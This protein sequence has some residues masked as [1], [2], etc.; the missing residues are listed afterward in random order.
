MIKTYYWHVFG[1]YSHY[2]TQREGMPWNAEGN[3]MTQHNDV[4]DIHY[5]YDRDVR[6]YHWDY[7][8]FDEKYTT[9]PLIHE[10][11]ML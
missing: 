7:F 4:L 6:T 2:R 9:R 11:V 5:K 10:R 1:S 3:V 8:P